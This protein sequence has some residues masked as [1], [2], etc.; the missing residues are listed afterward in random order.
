MRISMCVAEKVSLEHDCRGKSSIGQIQ[1]CEFP[2]IE[3]GGK[4]MSGSWNISRNPTWLVNDI[5]I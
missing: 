1:I 5:Y 4:I 3:P 2:R